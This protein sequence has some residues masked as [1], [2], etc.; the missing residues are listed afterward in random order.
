MLAGDDNGAALAVHGRRAL[1][2]SE[3]SGTSTCLP[4]FC[5]S[6]FALSFRAVSK[7]VL[8][9]LSLMD[10]TARGGSPLRNSSYLMALKSEGSGSGLSLRNRLRDRVE[11]CDL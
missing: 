7:L 6:T 11:D 4:H 10:R 5:S 2:N 3:E 9:L 8:V 1:P